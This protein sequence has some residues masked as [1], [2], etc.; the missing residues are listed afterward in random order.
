[1][2]RFLRLSAFHLFFHKE[3]V[4]YSFLPIA[5][6]YNKNVSNQLH[7]KTRNKHLMNRYSRM[8]QNFIP[9]TS[10]YRK[11]KYLQFIPPPMQS[12]GLLEKNKKKIVGAG[13]AEMKSSKK[14]SFE[15]A[16]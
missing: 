15:G 13:L 12:I 11:N 14:T 4:K 16:I 2:L 10:T 5:G 3:P 6:V 7:P 1:M 9:L 8:P